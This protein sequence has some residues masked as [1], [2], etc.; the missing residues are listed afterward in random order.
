MLA[1]PPMTLYVFIGALG[2]ICLLLLFFL[3]RRGREAA[4]W[5]EQLQNQIKDYNLLV[6]RFDLLGAE[7]TAWNNKN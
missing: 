1:L 5:Q 2:V 7:K 6:E 4:L 3:S